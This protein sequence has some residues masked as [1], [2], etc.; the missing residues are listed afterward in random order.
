MKIKA[1]QIY[2]SGVVKCAM[3]FVCLLFLNCNKL[4]TYS[5]DKSNPVKSRKPPSRWKIIHTICYDKIFPIQK[6]DIIIQLQILCGGYIIE[7]IT[8]KLRNGKLQTWKYKFNENWSFHYQDEYPVLDTMYEIKPKVVNYFIKTV[9]QLPLDSIMNLPKIEMI[10]Q[11]DNFLEELKG[12]RDY[13]L[14]I[15]QWYRLRRGMLFCGCAARIQLFHDFKYQEFQYRDG[16]LEAKCK[17]EKYAQELYYLIQDG[18]GC[19]KIFK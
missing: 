11:N 10:L 9:Q 7:G 1:G 5:K 8:L 3:L 17:A 2:P 15:I 12:P 4:G 13:M 14:K 18:Y 16:Y 6:S 19:E